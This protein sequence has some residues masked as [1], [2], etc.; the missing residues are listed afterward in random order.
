[1]RTYH[2]HPAQFLLAL[3]ILGICNIA[4]AANVP[5]GIQLAAK[6]E[7]VRNNGSEP[8]TLD[9]AL[10]ES[11]PANNVIRDLFEGLTATDGD[12]NI[13]PG[14]A[15]SWKQIDA[16]TW[17]FNL[18]KNAVWSNGD[19]ITTKDFLYGMRRFVDP[20]TASQYASSFGT[21]LLNGD[22]IVAG[23]M[24]PSALGVK[25]ID[26]Y[27]LEIKTAYPVGFMPSLVSN[28]QLGP[29]H[30]A[31]V[32][33]HGRDWTKP[34]NMVGNG[35]FKMASW[36]VNS[37]IV[38]VK[39]PSY[40]DAKNVQLT[41]MTYLPIEDLNAD[42]KMFE[43]GENDVVY[44]LPPGT[45][46]RYKSKY[47]KEIRNAP[48]LGL[49]YYSLFNKDP[50]LKDVRVRKALSMVLDRDILA[51]RV[52]ADG[53]V[54]AYGVIVRGTAGADVTT[55]DWAGWPMEKKVAEAKKLMAE[56]GLA[57]G[58]KLRFSYN[59]SDYHKKMAIFA[60]SEWKKKLGIDIE[61]EAMEFKVLIKKRNDGEY[62]IA[63]N[64]WIADYNDATTFLTLVQCDSAQNSQKNC[65]RKAE[66]LIDEANQSLDPIK[67]KAL[68][69]KAAKEI[70]DDY[71]MIPLL[72]YTIPR[73]VKTY[74]GGFNEAN[75][76][77]RYRAKDFYIIKH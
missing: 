18:R 49:R 68:L 46:E 19:K 29:V 13:V 7:M 45:Y 74:V 30:Q 75:S 40:W 23:K 9:P 21:F 76:M 57:P 10:A 5:A 70:M 16:K 36:D 37:K 6:Q 12:G 34:G 60:G 11:V 56:A 26:D 17:V 69:T 44:Q 14:V 53:Q 38:L 39:S 22:A 50:V 67:R 4:I 71:P 20:K 59:T 77:D 65:N 41:K 55:Y 35:A 51:E 47:P 28:L 73:L 24:P 25:A 8:E 3:I 64:G 58:S 48:M 66:A 2:P 54:P 27:T 1:M 72:Q 63:R 62:Q 33:K 52:T 61:L 31:T 42:V 15:E 32:E 43:S